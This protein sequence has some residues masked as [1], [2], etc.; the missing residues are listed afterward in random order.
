MHTV[1]TN[2]RKR[3]TPLLALFMRKME[4]FQCTQIYYTLSVVYLV[5]PE[6][7]TAPSP[8]SPKRHRP[9]GY[10]PL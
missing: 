9:Q 10:R 5:V 8:E 6:A 3:R 4:R 2:Q 7:T 1:R